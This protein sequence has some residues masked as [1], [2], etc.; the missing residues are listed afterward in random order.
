MTSLPMNCCLYKH[1]IIGPERSSTGWSCNPYCYY[2]FLHSEYNFI[3]K[4]PTTD[5]WDMECLLWVLT[6]WGRVTHICV[7]TLTITGSDNGLSPGR[8]QAVIWTNAEILLIGLLGTKF[9]EILIEIDTFYLKKMHLKVSSGK[10]RP[11]C[12]G[13]NVL[14]YNL[15]STIAIAAVYAKPCYNWPACTIKKLK[16]T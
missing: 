12:L 8:R 1:N 2:D 9:S 13:L 6:H 3:S 16:A 4:T 5:I 11:F 14:W 15:Y 7:G 10:W